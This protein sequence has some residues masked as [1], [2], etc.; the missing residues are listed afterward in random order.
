M[1]DLKVVPFTG[2]DINDIPARLRALADSIEA[3]HYQEVDS[4]VWLTL[5]PVGQCTH[6]GALG[7]LHPCGGRT[8]AVGA[9]HAAAFKLLRGGGHD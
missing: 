7:K 8:F 1:G 6:V 5:N 2:S 4:L 9:L 3:S